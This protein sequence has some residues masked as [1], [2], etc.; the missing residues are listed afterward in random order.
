MQLISYFRGLGFVCFLGGVCVFGMG[1]HLLIAED[2]GP[3]T[4]LFIS[5][6]FTVL[7]LS[8]L[9]QNEYNHFCKYLVANIHQASC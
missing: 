1:R 8:E 4:V 3:V 6:Y 5:Q 7:K 2:L 9:W